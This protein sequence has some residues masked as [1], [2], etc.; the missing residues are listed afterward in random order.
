[1]CKNFTVITSNGVDTYE[2]IGEL[3]VHKKKNKD[4]HVVSES[5]AKR[6]HNRAMNMCSYVRMR[7]HVHEIIM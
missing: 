5:D 1:M 6:I 7:K 4:E 3:F 2:S